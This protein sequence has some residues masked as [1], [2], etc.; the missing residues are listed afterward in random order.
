M[1]IVLHKLIIII[2]IIIR[3]TSSISRYLETG[4]S[5]EEFSN[6]YLH[7]LIRTFF[8]IC[9]NICFEI[10]INA[11][12]RNQNKR[13]NTKIKLSYKFTLIIAT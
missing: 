13:D 11:Q 3:P 8:R 1:N 6:R 12:Q 7:L 9:L 2:I 5:A 4:Q 10:L